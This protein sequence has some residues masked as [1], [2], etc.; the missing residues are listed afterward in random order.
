VLVSLVKS[1]FSG[2]QRD[3][4]REVTNIP[5]INHRIGTLE[6]DLEQVHLIIGTPAPSSIDPRRYAAS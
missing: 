4:V 3:A 1:S 5:T 2:L 6:K